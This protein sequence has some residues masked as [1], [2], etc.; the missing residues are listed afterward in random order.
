MLCGHVFENVPCLVNTTIYVWRTSHQ[1]IKL[2]V[3]PPRPAPPLTTSPLSTHWLTV[4]GNKLLSFGID[5]STPRSPASNWNS[6][7]TNGIN[8]LIRFHMHQP[9]TYS[10][11][12]NRPLP[13]T[14]ADEILPLQCK[15]EGSSIWPTIPSTTTLKCEKRF[16]N[17]LFDSNRR[18]QW[19][20]DSC[21][22]SIE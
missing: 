3:S 16:G 5:F 21:Q 17:W 8:L 13:N 11:P 7:M 15:A 20:D 2:F 1:S 6:I 10:Q 12:T 4:K 18:Q 14:L 9:A 19:T 22:R